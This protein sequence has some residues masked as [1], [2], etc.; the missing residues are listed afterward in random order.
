MKKL[1]G[2]LL[3]ADHSF[4]DPLRGVSKPA[5]ARIGRHEL[6]PGPSLSCS[7]EPVPVLVVRC[8]L[9]ARERPRGLGACDFA[10]SAYFAHD[11]VEVIQFVL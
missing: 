7:L 3:G 5:R 1:S 2:P 11:E 10:V 8:P 4:L 6:M 9:S